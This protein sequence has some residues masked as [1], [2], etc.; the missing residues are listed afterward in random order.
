MVIDKLL[1]LQAIN[2]FFK[3]S[4]LKSKILIY[5]DD[6]LTVAKKRTQQIYERSVSIYPI[7]DDNNFDI[8]SSK[9]SGNC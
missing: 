8:I 6:I 2:S 3:Q 1:S 7:T 5:L 4:T 9:G